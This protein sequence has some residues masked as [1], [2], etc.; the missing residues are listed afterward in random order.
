MKLPDGSI[1]INGELTEY[2][3]SIYSSLGYRETTVSN[4]KIPYE[5][6]KRW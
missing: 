1:P 6:L 3:T 4:K 2:E 5:Q